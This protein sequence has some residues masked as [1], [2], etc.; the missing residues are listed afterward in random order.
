M[1][2]AYMSKQMNAGK[3]CRIYVQW[4]KRPKLESFGGSQMFLETIMLSDIN[5]R[6]VL[7][8]HI[9]SFR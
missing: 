9:V 5:Q 4:V 1:E 7:E 8:Y 2:A 6:H 3:K